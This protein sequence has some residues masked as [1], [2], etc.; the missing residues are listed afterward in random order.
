VPLTSNLCGFVF[1]AQALHFGGVVPF[2]L[3]NAI[4]IRT[5]F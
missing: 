2:A 1:T 4:D 3:S 5:G